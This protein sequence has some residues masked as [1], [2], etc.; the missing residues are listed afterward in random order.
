M[1]ALPVQGKPFACTGV[2]E[3]RYRRRATSDT[4]TIRFATTQADFGRFAIFQRQEAQEPRG[5]SHAVS[6]WCKHQL[7]TLRP[8]F[9]AWSFVND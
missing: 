9:F 1:G 6:M 4:R 3:G 2:F 7:S 5:I 8:S